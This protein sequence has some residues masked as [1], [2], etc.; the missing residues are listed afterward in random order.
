MAKRENKAWYFWCNSDERKWY[1][2]AFVNGRGSCS[3]RRWEAK[4]GESLPKQV[5]KGSDWQDEFAE[6]LYGTSFRVHLRRKPN[7][8]KNCKSRLPPEILSE[9]KEQVTELHISLSLILLDC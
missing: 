6:Y 7:L 8:E 3:L 2:L 9:I 5:V 4:S 1:V